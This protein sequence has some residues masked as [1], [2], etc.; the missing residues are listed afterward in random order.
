MDTL[1]GALKSWTIWAN[2]VFVVAAWLINHQEVL[3]FLHLDAQAQVT[4]LAVLNFLL[5]F[6]TTESLSEKG[7]S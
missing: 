4:V 6:K 2:T 7:L 3:T 1:I 5:R